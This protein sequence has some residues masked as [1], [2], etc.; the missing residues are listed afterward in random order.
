M[1]RPATAMSAI[2]LLLRWRWRCGPGCPLMT[3]SSRSPPTAR[4]T[5]SRVSGQQARSLR[6]NLQRQQPR[7]RRRPCHCRY[8]RA[9]PAAFAVPITVSIPQKLLVGEMNDLVIGVGANAGVGEIGFTV[10]FDASVLQVRDASQGGWAVD[11]G[12]NPRFAAEISGAEDRVQIR[13]AVSGPGR[14]FRRK[15]GRRAIPACCAGTTSVLITD[16]VVKD[17]DGRPMI[18]ALSASN[19]QVTVESGTSP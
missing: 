5:Q 8:R 11:V 4:R 19:L 13:S 14:P 2:G 9:A 1:R 15:R 12:V 17:A 7:Q 18:P 3:R 6:P 16:V 10:Q